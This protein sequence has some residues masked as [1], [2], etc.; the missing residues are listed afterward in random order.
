MVMHRSSGMSDGG[1]SKGFDEMA[2]AEDR[3]CAKIVDVILDNLAPAQRIAVYIERRI[4][5]QVSAFDTA[6]YETNLKAAKAVIGRELARCGV[7]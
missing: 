2:E 7:W 4:M 5:R 1:T 3:R 6:N